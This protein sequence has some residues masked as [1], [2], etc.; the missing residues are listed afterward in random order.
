MKKIAIFGSGEI[1]KRVLDILGNDI[2][3]FFV[4]NYP[5]ES[6]CAGMPLIS[7]EEY[8]ERSNEVYR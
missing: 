3:S 5:E 2:V 6:I 1:G 4:S 8:L 7:F